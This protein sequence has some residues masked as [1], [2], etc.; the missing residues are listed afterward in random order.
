MPYAKNSLV[1]ATMLAASRPYLCRSSAPGP[2]SPKV[3]LTPIFLSGVGH[4]SHRTSGNGAAQATDHGVL[5]DGHD[6][7]GLGGALD[8]QVG[9]D[10]LDGVHVDDLGIDALGSKLLSSLELP[11]RPSGRQ[12]MMVTSVPSRMTMPLPTSNL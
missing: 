4:C 6:V 8:D 5:L 2:D 12:A 7:A 1:V 3:S 11:R 9:V 10:G